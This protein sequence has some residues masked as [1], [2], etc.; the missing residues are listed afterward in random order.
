[1]ETDDPLP[2]VSPEVA[3]ADEVMITRETPSLVEI[4]ANLA[5]D[6]FLVLLDTDYPGW[7]AYVDGQPRPIMRAYYRTRAIYLEAGAHTVQFI[8]RPLSFY[9]G[10][11]LAV[12]GLVLVALFLANWFGY[13]IIKFNAQN[14]LETRRH[15]YD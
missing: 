1:L 2:E 10:V 3:G 5:G 9:G 13:S 8:Y 14:Q 4:Q 15:S 11:V 6:G 7:R 12:V